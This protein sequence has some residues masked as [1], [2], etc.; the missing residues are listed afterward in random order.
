MRRGS[1]SFFAAGSGAAAAA[2]ARAP[3]A[4]LFDSQR[5]CSSRGPSSGRESAE[6]GDRGIR[7]RI[8]PVARARSKRAWASSASASMRVSR[9]VASEVWAL[10]TSIEEATPALKR[11]LASSSSSC[12]SRT[13][14]WA[15]STR[16][17]GV[18]VG[19]ERLADLLLDLALGVVLLDQELVALRLGLRRRGPRSA[20][21]SKIGTL[22]TAATVRLHS[23]SRT[24]LP[25]SV[26]CAWAPSGRQPLGRAPPRC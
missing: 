24:R 18:V 12:A 19:E 26:P 7:E 14:C 9:A 17:A 3:A 20:G 2:P 25:L 16:L 5:D 10:S 21:R 4:L 8:S 1:P 22:T 23:R 6:F 11:S 15:S 13:P